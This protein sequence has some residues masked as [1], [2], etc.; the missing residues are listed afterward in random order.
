[1]AYAAP[2]ILQQQSYLAPSSEIWALGILFSILLSGESIYRDADAALRNEYNV[3]TFANLSPDCQHILHL[4][5][6]FDPSQR[7]TIS[8][9]RYHPWL[10]PTIDQIERRS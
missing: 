7:A 9:L 2:E 10:K 4:C 1:V 6:Q 3:A 5:L 8:E